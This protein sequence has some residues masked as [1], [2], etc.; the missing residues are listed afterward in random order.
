MPRN[1][2]FDYSLA[3][4]KAMDIFWK[5]GY[6]NS[7][8]HC[9]IDNLGIGRGSFYNAFQSK[10]KLFLLVLDH[11]STTMIKYLNEILQ[12]KPFKTA[13]NNLFST[14]IETILNDNRHQ[15]CLM[16][17]ATTEF[18]LSDTEVAKKVNDYHKK[19]V[20]CLVKA[21]SSAIDIGEI[22]SDKDPKAI[23]LFLINTMDGLRVMAKRTSKREMFDTVIS[24]AL[25]IVG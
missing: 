8:M 4:D 25:S 21:I 1:K 3:I 9:L 2:E 18:G 14:L 24:A 15:G 19:S 11:Y 13:I 5:N 23:A 17:N 10:R 6:K 22:Q 12:Q 7:S 20:D 16:T